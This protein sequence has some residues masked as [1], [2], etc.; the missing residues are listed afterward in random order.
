MEVP[1]A[2][3]VGPQ[4]CGLDSPCIATRIQ[5]GWLSGGIQLRVLEES[6]RHAYERIAEVWA[7]WARQ[8]GL[9]H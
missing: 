4:S 9:A 5:T 2:G 6:N 7:G 3:P 8:F 1:I